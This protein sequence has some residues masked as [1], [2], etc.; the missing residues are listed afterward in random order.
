MAEDQLQD[1]ISLLEELS[2]DNAVPRNIKIKFQQII[3]SLNK[4][5]ETSM[6]VSKALQELEDVADDTNIQA[7]VRT[8]IWNVISML[9]KAAAQN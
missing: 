3:T 2:D 7:Y 6:K 8:Q 1:I 4:K 9:E 5:G